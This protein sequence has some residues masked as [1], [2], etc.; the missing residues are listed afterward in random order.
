MPVKRKQ[1]HSQKEIK[2]AAKILLW[3]RN[4]RNNLSPFIKQVF[5]TVS[6]GDAYLHNWHID[7]IAEHLEAVYKKQILR[8]II[9]IPPRYLKSISATVAFPAWVLGK[10]SSE[11]I[12]AASYSHFLA[13]KHSQDCR[14]VLQ[15]EWYNQ[16]FPNTI[17][18][19]GQ[20]EKRKFE[21]IDQGH[22]TAVSVGGTTTGLGGNILIVDDPIDP[23]KSFSETERLKA[24]RWL[25]LTF[26]TRLDDKK[27]GAIII[28]MQRL[29]QDDCC[30]HAIKKDKDRWTVLKLPGEYQK[31]TIIEFKEVNNLGEVKKRKRTLKKNTLLHSDYEGRSE[32]EQQKKTLGTYG[33]SSQYQ[34]NPTPEGGGIIKLE[35]FKRFKFT[36]SGTDIVKISQFWDTAQKPDEVLNSPWV[37]G[38]FISTYTAHYLVH[39]FRDWLNYPDG[40]KKVKDLHAKWKPNVIVIEDK[41]TGQSLLQELTGLPTLGFEPE[42]DKVTRLSTE[43]PSVE[44]GNIYLPE[45]ADWL[46]DFEEEI[47]LFPNSTYKDQAD[48][49]SMALR[50]FRLN[51]ISSLITIR[52]AKSQVA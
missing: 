30:G 24:N 44:A 28:V 26:S 43:S 39:V 50:Y 4:L 47:G 42:G 27:T 46:F 14:T 19:F 6:A 36:P 23:E 20:V 31:R 17:L 38:T 49:F 35:W 51:H 22:R 18:K 8:L 33:F 3:R 13:Y 29:H 2:E 48:M 37:C 52:G 41:S 32:I 40:K 12:M 11:K 1:Q 21:T 25:D 16:V 9:N 45:H 7:C 5:E 15:S 34:Q 10:N